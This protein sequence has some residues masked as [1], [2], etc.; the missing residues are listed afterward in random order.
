VIDSEMGTFNPN[1]ALVLHYNQALQDM[2]DDLED[3][4]E[5]LLEKMP[6]IFILAATKRIPFDKLAENPNKI[7]KAVVESDAIYTIL[8]IVS[9]YRRAA[10]NIKLPPAYIFLKSLTETYADT[11]IQSMIRLLEQNDDDNRKKG[12]LQIPTIC[13][14]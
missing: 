9:D 10:Q 7:R 2:Q 4:E 8:D 12:Y 1:T 14:A 5:D 3:I 13:S 11:L 6:N